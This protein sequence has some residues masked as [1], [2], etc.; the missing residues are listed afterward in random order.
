MANTI[1]DPSREEVWR[2]VLARRAK[3]GLT[4]REFCRRE[5]LHESAF[6]FW[7]RT[8]QE[9]D[10]V[11]HGSQDGSQDG[12]RQCRPGCGGGKTP[13]FVPLMIDVRQPAAGITLELR[14]G[15]SLRLSELF[16]VD[17]LAALVHAL[18]ANTIETHALET[19]EGQ[20]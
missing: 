6:Y 4:V 3:S 10:A 12:L 16:P 19:H 15:R 17:R 8:I 20:P 14:D 7:R 2:Q 18:E 13:A 5:G 1:R 11:R 9:R